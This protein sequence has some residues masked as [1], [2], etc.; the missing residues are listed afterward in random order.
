MTHSQCYSKAFDPEDAN[1]CILA[2][3]GLSSQCN[4]QA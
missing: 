4:I 1:S 2:V 3:L